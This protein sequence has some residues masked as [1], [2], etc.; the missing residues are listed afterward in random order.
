MMSEVETGR[1]MLFERKSYYL[2]LRMFR[3]LMVTGV[4]RDNKTTNNSACKMG[5]NRSTKNSHHN[6]DHQTSRSQG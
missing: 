3:K 1:V 5:R 2:R 6:S 4:D